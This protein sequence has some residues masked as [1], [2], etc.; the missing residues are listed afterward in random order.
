MNLWA[1]RGVS[2]QRPQPSAME[3]TGRD[4][5]TVQT[6]PRPRPV[7]RF[8]MMSPMKKSTL[9]GVL[10]LSLLIALP[11]VAELPYGVGE[12][13]IYSVSYEDTMAGVCV[14]RVEKLVRYQGTEALKLTMDIDSSAAFSDFFYVKDRMESLFDPERLASLRY[15]K[16]LIEDT[17]TADEVLYYDQ[18][19]NTITSATKVRNGI[20]ANGCDALAAFYHVRAHDIHEGADLSYPYADA[21]RN[22]IVEITVL[23]RETITVPAGTFD[24]YKLRPELQEET[25][26]FKE[27][28]TLYIWVSADE[29]QLPIQ[30]VGNTWFGKIHARLERYV[31]AD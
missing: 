23:G 30:I 27:E 10:L 3:K 28:G 2:K 16:H 13:L 4:R 15:E 17:Y 6:R 11:A 18:E 24:C 20:V 29:H 26:I 31:L 25:G 5:Y 19:A 12:K 7:E 9:A 21:T 1:D 14:M 22:E 8:L